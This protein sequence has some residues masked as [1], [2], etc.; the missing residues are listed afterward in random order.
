M[1]KYIAIS[2]IALF[3][4][5]IANA[6]CGSCAKDHDKS[7][8]DSKSECSCSAKCSEKKSCSKESKSNQSCGKKGA[9]SGSSSCGG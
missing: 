3:S 1:K 2:I 9:D 5:A 7:A 8:Q 4:A 6:H